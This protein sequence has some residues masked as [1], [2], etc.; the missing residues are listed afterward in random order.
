MYIIHSMINSTSFCREKVSHA[1]GFVQGNFC[2]GGQKR[3]S[4]DHSTNLSSSAFSRRDSSE[5]APTLSSFQS[6]P[7]LAANLSIRPKSGSNTILFSPVDRKL[8][9]NQ[10][11]RVGV[12]SGD[13]RPLTAAV[14]E[15]LVINPTD[16]RFVYDKTFHSLKDLN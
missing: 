15:R 3:L 4:F 13:F 11:M 7:I 12:G 10:G 2:H 9:I 1:G 14:K 5:S 6:L 8:S 16:G